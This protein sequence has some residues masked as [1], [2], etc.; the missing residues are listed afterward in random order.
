MELGDRKRTAGNERF[1]P[2]EQ[3]KYCFH[4]PQGSR[5]WG[6]DE[7]LT[8][9]FKESKTREIASPATAKVALGPA[10]GLG[11]ASGFPSQL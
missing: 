7:T 4:G 2:A 3:K 10:F 6:K 9:S 1:C 11:M 8:F 5:G